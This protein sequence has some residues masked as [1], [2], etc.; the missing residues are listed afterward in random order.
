MTS[1]GFHNPEQSPRRANGWLCGLA[2]TAGILGTNLTAQAEHADL[3]K[4]RVERV[5]DV[6]GSVWE[7][8]IVPRPLYGRGPVPCPQDCVSVSENSQA[9]P[10]KETPKK[11]AGIVPPAPAKESK[12]KP[13]KANKP[14][15][16]IKSATPSKLKKAA[17]SPPPP[18]QKESAKQDQVGIF[19]RSTQWV[20]LDD[21]EKPDLDSKAKKADAEPKTDEDLKVQ[22]VPRF[23]YPVAGPSSACCPAEIHQTRI[24]PGDYWR[25]YRSIPF[26]RSEYVANPSYRHDAT[27][28]ILFGQL[29]PTVVQKLPAQPRPHNTL[30]PFENNFIR[31]NSYYSLGGGYGANPGPFAYPGAYGANL[32]YPGAQLSR[33]PWG[34]TIPYDLTPGY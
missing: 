2:L 15:K 21:T 11:E 19:P 10:S 16:P 31:P 32:N 26:L 24:H 30:F 7:V 3:T 9:T 8:L 4:P 13:K 25:V 22:I 23:P 29:R 33:V 18:P 17:P 20:S 12:P 5:H 27:M 14:K 6:D 1:T 28:E 34:F